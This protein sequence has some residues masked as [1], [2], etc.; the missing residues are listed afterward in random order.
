MFAHYRAGLPV[1]QLLDRTP[2]SHPTG[3]RM[4]GYEDSF[5]K[6]RGAAEE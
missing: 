6:R 2:A 4:P 3:A 5:W 1:F